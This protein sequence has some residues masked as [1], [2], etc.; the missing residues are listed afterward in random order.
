MTVQQKLQ[1]ELASVKKQLD[2]EKKRR[3]NQEFDGLVNKNSLEK[4]PS[5]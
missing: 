3:Y 4:K 2:Q 1:K 5:K